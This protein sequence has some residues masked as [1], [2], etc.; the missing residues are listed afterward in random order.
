MSDEFVRDSP[1]TSPTEKLYEVDISAITALTEEET[2]IIL[3]LLI[4]WGYQWEAET[5][6]RALFEMEAVTPT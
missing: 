6:C 3:A 1:D 2:L 5:V 4:Q